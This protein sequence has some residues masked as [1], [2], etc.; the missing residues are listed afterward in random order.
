MSKEEEDFITEEV[1][2]LLEKGAIIGAQQN[3]LNYYSTIFTVPKRG[4]E[5]RPII[6]LRNLNTFIP[7]THFKMEGIHSLRDII[8]SGD[9]MIKLDLK[10][11]YFAVPI[12]PTHQKYLSFRWKGQVFQFTCLPFGLSSAPRTFTKV[13]KPVVSYLRSLGVRMIVYLDDIL[14]LGQTKE[15]VLK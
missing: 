12:H 9:F 10:E 4:G 7:H 14:I 1:Q 11:A 13:M 2:S 6:N 15:E 3:P 8:L 5:R